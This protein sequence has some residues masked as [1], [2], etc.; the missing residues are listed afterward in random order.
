MK[1]DLLKASDKLFYLEENWP[2]FDRIE[3]IATF[4]KKDLH[5]SLCFID[6]VLESV[7]EKKLSCPKEKLIRL[8]KARLYIVILI[9]MRIEALAMGD[10]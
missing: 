5:C 8:L 3:C 10:G 9:H 4:S 2:G 7:T 1:C 6:T